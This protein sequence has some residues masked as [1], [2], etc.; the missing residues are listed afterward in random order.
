MAHFDWTKICC[1]C[2]LRL[3]FC[4]RESERAG[5]REASFGKNYTATLDRNYAVLNIILLI[6]FL[7]SFQHFGS[8]PFVPHTNV[9]SSNLSITV[10][11]FSHELCIIDGGILVR[12]LNHKKI[13]LFF[14]LFFKI[15]VKLTSPHL[16]KSG[17]RVKFYQTNK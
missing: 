11:T 8:S 3:K 7:T 5:E 9:Q 13:C 17:S 10:T 2:S 6:L 16:G 12:L 1:A 14:F 15:N 4:A